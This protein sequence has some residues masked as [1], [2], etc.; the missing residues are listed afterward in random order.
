MELIVISSEDKVFNEI[1]VVNK[2]FIN[3]LKIFHL[4]KN[5][6]SEEIYSRFIERIDSKYHNR[7]VL[8]DHHHL[9]NEFNLKGI[10]LKELIRQ[11]VEIDFENYKRDIGFSET[12]HSLSS[13]FHSKDEIETSEIDFDYLFLSPVF[14]SISKKKYS[15]KG[16]EVSDIDKKIFALGGISE[17][18]IS[19]AKKLGYT[20]IAV[21][22]SVWNAENPIKEFKKIQDVCNQV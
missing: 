18:N 15:G 10:H 5:N 8:H 7:I 13:S 16:F 3:G 11:D 1:E 9:I 20:G 2:L 19:E 22:G 17:N 21:L 14:D 6:A 4:R 12:K